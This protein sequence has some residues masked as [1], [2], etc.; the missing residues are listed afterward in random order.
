VQIGYN[1]GV[2]N[3]PY[4]YSG[5]Y[6]DTESRYTFLRARYYDPA[7]GRFI[8]ED[9]AFDGNN[10]Y[11]YCR[12][13]PVN[14]IDPSGLASVANLSIVSYGSGG[15]TSLDTNGHAFIMVV[16]TH[17][18][19]I[20]V[21][22]KSVKKGG[23]VTVGTFG[24]RSAHNGVWYNIEAYCI[25]SSSRVSLTKAITSKQLKK[26]SKKIR[27]NDKWG[28]IKN[29]SWFAAKVWNSINS[30]S[31]KVKP[32][33]IPTPAKLAAN[34]KEHKGYQTE[35]AIPFNGLKTICYYNGSKLVYDERGADQF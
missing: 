26:V 35:I 33:V 34:I 1:A 28:L 11:I 4:R 6:Y 30:G 16:N 18:K 21:G 9:P 15:S 22:R 12:N 8:S 32:G 3:N 24:N 27:N 25:S 20:K 14:R 29:C 17:T 7:I 10:W 13:D 19:K 23:S 5:E 31:N 2:D